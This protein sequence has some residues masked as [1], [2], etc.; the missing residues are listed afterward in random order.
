M[1]DQRIFKP[2][3]IRGIYPTELNEEAAYAIGRAFARKAKAKEII[4]G[5]DMRLSGPV[6]KEKL[7]AGIIDEMEG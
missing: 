5:S 3:D 1:I 2:Y 4:I 7:I 6:L